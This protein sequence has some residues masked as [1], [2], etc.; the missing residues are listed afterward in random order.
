MVKPSQKEGSLIWF[1]VL[2]FALNAGAILS[3]YW[4]QIPRGVNVVQLT[5]IDFDD[6]PP[7]GDPEAEQQPEQ[8][9]QPEP[10]P[11]PEPEPTPPPLD[12]PPEFE[13]P[14]PSPTPIA[15][16]QSRPKPSL[17]PPKQPAP[18]HPN[19]AATPTKAWRPESTAEQVKAARAPDFFFTNRNHLIRVPPGR[20]KS[21]E[22]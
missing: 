10:T 6:L 9:P 14:V 8:P 3:G 1:L 16:P 15:S 11:P 4:M 13:I 20:C 2:S 18:S 7:K 22:M 12:K 17:K 5:D 21:L 19:P